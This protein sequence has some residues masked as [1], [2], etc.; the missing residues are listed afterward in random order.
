M[1]P[2][3]ER[4]RSFAGNLVIAVVGG[5]LIGVLTSFGQSALPF[6]L[7]PL[8]NSSGSWSLAAFLLALVELRPRRGALLGAVALG[9]MLLGYVVATQ[10]RGFPVGRSLLIFWGAASVVVGPA[11]G[12]GAVWVR[13]ND[14]TRAAAGIALIAGILIGEG[15]Y[16]LTVVAE[17]T[18]AQYWVGEIVVGLGVATFGSVRRIRTLRHTAVGACLTAIVAALFWVAYSG[19]LMGLL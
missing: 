16:G 13:G 10:L 19:N 15:V 3:T 6:E 4:S 5:G 17:T 18:P 8:A 7:S 2:A 11:L 9:M 12:A 1:D 14:P